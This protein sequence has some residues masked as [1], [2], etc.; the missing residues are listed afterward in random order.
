MRREPLHPGAQTTLF[1]S[2]DYRYWGFY[3]DRDDDPVELDRFM[4]A[5]AHVEKNIGRLKESG[6]ERFPFC[7]F[8]ANS[9]WL[10]AVGFS[11]SLVRWFQ[12]LCLDGSLR[13]A[14]PKA[15]RWRLW[16]APA[17]L[18]RSG[19]QTILRVLDGWPD[20]DALVDAHRRIAHRLT[21]H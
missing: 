20:A 15:L 4:R 2:L 5:H 10:A 13:T 9:A 16:H 19:R 21:K 14:E 6:W 7:D 1:P 12:L 17:R 18:I 11:A 3:A 8:E